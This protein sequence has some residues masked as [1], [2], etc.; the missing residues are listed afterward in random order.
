[1]WYYRDNGEESPIFRYPSNKKGKPTMVARV[2][3]SVGTIYAKLTIITQQYA[4]LQ[5]EADQVRKEILHDTQNPASYNT[6]TL[7][8]ISLMAQKNVTKIPYEAVEI[9]NQHLTGGAKLALENYID[10]HFR[11]IKEA[12]ATINKIKNLT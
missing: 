3:H 8:N 9:S 12:E 6:A 4:N 2:I 7:S 5:V 1:M 10:N 11:T